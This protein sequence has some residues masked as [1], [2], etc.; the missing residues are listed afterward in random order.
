MGYAKWIDK[1][2]NFLRIFEGL[3]GRSKMLAQA[4]RQFDAANGTPIRWVVAEEKLAGALRK[5]FREVRLEIEVIHVPPGFVESSQLMRETYYAGVYWHARLESA[6]ACARRAER[7]FHLLGRCDPAWT[8]WYE[9][10]DSFEEARRRQFT[11]TATHFQ[12][13]FA[14]KDHQIGDG[15]SFSLW[16]GDNLQETSGIDVGCGYSSLR[17]HSSC[18][19]TPCNGGPIG[20]RVLTASVMTEVLRAIALA[21]EPEWGVVTSHQY[22]ELLLEKVMP[23]G[24][25]VGWVMYFSRLRGKVPPL[26]EPVRIEPV[27]DQGTLVIL[28]SERF[29]AANPEHVELAARVHEVLSQAGLLRKLQPWISPGD[30]DSDDP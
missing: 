26:P 2:M 8:R 29:S 4:R 30:S 28:T 20:E 10:A 1:E 6:E 19:L 11:T 25:S 15:F 22:D 13:L 23:A 12:K 18:V 5:M 14:Q 24:T 16:T 3:E 27:E 9:T 17:L 21:W 7:F